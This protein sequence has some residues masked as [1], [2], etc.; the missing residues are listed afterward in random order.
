MEKI[1]CVVLYGAKYMVEQPTAS[2]RKTKYDDLGLFTY[3]KDAIMAGEVYEKVLQATQLDDIIPCE[4]YD[5]DKVILPE[6]DVANIT[7][8]NNITEFIKD[9]EVMVR[10]VDKIGKKQL[11]KILVSL[12][13]MLNPNQQSII[14]RLISDN[15][16][17]RRLEKDSPRVVEDCKE[18]N[19][20]LKALRDGT[21]QV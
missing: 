6:K 16:L 15:E 5:V 3:K 8:Y 13:L 11:D 9:N 10:C 14:T 21:L 20:F 4:E 19:D 7:Y 18:N 12:G 1:T 2:K 17:K